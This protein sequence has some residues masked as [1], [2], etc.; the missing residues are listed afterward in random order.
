MVSEEMEG[1]DKV[2]GE[3]GKKKK[4]KKRSARQKTRR[5]LW[6]IRTK[7]ENQK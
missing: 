5:T 7:E 3:R 6:L 4:K 1:K 2:R